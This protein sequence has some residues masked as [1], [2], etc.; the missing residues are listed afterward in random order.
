MAKWPDRAKKLHEHLEANPRAI[1]ALTPCPRPNSIGSWTPSAFSAFS[2][3]ASTFVSRHAFGNAGRPSR[4]IWRCTSSAPPIRAS[5]STTSRG[6]RSSKRAGCASR[7]RPATTSSTARRPLKPTRTT[8]PSG[9]P[10]GVLSGAHERAG[11]ARGRSGRDGAEFRQVDRSAA[12]AHRRAAGG[13]VCWTRERTARPRA[14]T[15]NPDRA[16]P[17]RH[18]QGEAG[19]SR[20]DRK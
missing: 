8:M 13:S 4:R 7:A 14:R 10:A 19:P 5:C 12:S 17:P 18:R 15:P 16:T 2:N 3:L 1:D 6:S 11:D 20:R 9:R